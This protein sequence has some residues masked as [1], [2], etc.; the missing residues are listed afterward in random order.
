MRQEINAWIRRSG[1]FD[2]VIDLDAVLR[3]PGHP[4]RLLPDYDSGDHLH[5]NDMGYAAAAKAIPLELL[6][7]G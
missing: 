3:D 5:T 2:A 4:S 6:Q 7:L 1:E